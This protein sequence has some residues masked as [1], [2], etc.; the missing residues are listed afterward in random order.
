MSFIT[1]N[2]FN[3]FRHDFKIKLLLFSCHLLN[4]TDLAR[5]L[6]KNWRIKKREPIH[7]SHVLMNEIE[8][9]KRWIEWRELPFSPIFLSHITFY[10]ISFLSSATQQPNHHY[11]RILPRPFRF[12]VCEKFS[13]FFSACAVSYLSILS[14]TLS[15]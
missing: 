6:R 10:F 8:V 1:F 11:Y 14:V 7:I 4:D 5:F 15:L 3:K 12:T 9:G 2:W 13:I